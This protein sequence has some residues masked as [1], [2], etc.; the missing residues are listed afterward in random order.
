MSFITGRLFD[1]I[2]F[3][4][5]YR[6]Q[7]K[8]H[9]SWKMVWKILYKKYLVDFFCFHT[10]FVKIFLSTLKFH[11]KISIDSQTDGHTTWHI[12]STFV[13]NKTKQRKIMFYQIDIWDGKWHKNTTWKFNMI[14]FSLNF[15][16][17]LERIY[18]TMKTLTHI[19]NDLE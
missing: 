8:I 17:N 3:S 5:Q 2:Y 12:K 11:H 15:C 9:K 16:H 13:S 14:F 18:K 7:K 6:I 10:I 1:I 4:L 19:N